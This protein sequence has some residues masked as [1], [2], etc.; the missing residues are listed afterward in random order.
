LEDDGV[1]ERFLTADYDLL[2]IGFY[3]GEDNPYSPPENIPFKDGVGQITPEQESL[4][5]A[6]NDRVSTRGYNA[7]NVSHHGP[8][9]Q[10]SKSPYIDYPLTVFLPESVADGNP[11]RTIR[12]GEDLGFRDI[13][14][15]MLV[16][17]LR[18]KGYDLYD[19]TE[20]PGWK[21]T[22]SEG[23]DG[24]ELEDSPLLNDYVEELPF[25]TCDSK[26]GSSEIS[27]ATCQTPQNRE[28]VL[29][30]VA[31]DGN[32][33]RSP[34]EISLWP[35]PNYESYITLTIQASEEMNLKWKIIDA[36]G[37]VRLAEKFG[38]TQGES[39]EQL[40]ISGLEPGMYHFVTSTGTAKT[41]IRM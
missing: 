35:N 4:V 20:A 8:E 19:N 25:R 15:K 18:K 41:F 24:F 27:S 33:N 9:N 37:T 30:P 3:K 14:L 16:N 32:A 10:F 1:T 12:M 40:N 11:I 39:I 29:N 34:I 28:G 23:L 6:L 21:W 13:E 36:I 31:A 2:M 7:G 26:T 17:E 38:L 22:W 5:Q